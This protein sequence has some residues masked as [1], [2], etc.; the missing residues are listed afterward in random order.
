MKKGFTLI[1]LLAVLVV[2]A[3]L[4]AIISPSVIDLLDKRKQDLLDI[5]ISEIEQAARDWGAKNMWALPTGKDLTVVKR[6][7]EIKNGTDTEYGVLIINLRLLKE[8]TNL[9]NDIKNPVTNTKF[10]DDL[11]IYITNEATKISYKVKEEFDE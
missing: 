11:E 6:Y 9:N 10:S 4:I 8:T 2:M 3:L 5:Q 7:D 1:E